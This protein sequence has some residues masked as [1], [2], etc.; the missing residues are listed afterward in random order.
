VTGLA[1]TSVP[2]RLNQ[3]MSVPVSNAN[4]SVFAGPV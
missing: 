3:R 1:V 4:W 2:P